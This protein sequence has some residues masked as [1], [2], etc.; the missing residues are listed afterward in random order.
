[1]STDEDAA[2]LRRVP[3]GWWAAIR[4]D[5]RAALERDP[6]ARHWLEVVLCYPG[7]HAL[8]LHRV[9]HLLWRC[10]LKL[11]AR[12]VGYWARFL[13]G[14]EIHPAARIG[15]GFFI[16]HGMGVVIG[17]TAEIGENVTLY[18][19]VT[20]G[21]R[22]MAKTK[23]HP[24]VG[25]NVVIGAGA[26][27]LGPVRIGDNARI[28][29]GSVVVRDVPPN[30]VVVGVPG[31]VTFRDGVPTADRVDLEHDHLPDPVVRAL[32]CLLERVTV[33]EEQVETLRRAGKDGETP[34]S[35]PYDEL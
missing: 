27:V 29:A 16:D 20:L 18:H 11:V 33:L 15:G 9:A 7:W 32:E 6:A 14:I 34:S 8:M 4:R 13:T 12:V 3:T 1:M 23:R 24:T 21:G 26:E 28:G 30:S 2:A 5:I 31:R 25:E 10:R 22:S 17:E 35:H 19:G